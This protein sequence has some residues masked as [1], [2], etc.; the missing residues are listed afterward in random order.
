MNGV[1]EVKALLVYKLE[2]FSITKTEALQNKIFT[3]LIVSP[4]TKVMYIELDKTYRWAL[5]IKVSK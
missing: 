5:G 1:K 4:E 2:N 3:L